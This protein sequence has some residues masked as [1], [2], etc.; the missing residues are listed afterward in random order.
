M[1]RNIISRGHLVDET[2]T[3]MMPDIFPITV[4]TR[5]EFLMGH[6]LLTIELNHVHLSVSQESKSEVKYVKLIRLQGQ[7]GICSNFSNHSPNSR[8]IL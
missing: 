4:H 6:T 7:T 8:E 3:T 2:S 1:A 5:D